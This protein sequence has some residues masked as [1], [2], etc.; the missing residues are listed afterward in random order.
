[1]SLLDLFRVRNRIVH[2]LPAE[3]YVFLHLLDQDANGRQISG[4]VEIAEGSLSN[5]LAT[6]AY[7]LDLEANCLADVD[8]KELTINTYLTPIVE[9]D[10]DFR[11]RILQMASRKEPSFDGFTTASL[12]GGDVWKHRDTTYCGSWLI[13]L[14]CHDPELLN[15]SADV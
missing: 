9:H 15:S 10:S 7:T 11:E 3:T 5:Q 1:M 14:N 2:E 8:I 4:T 6:L 13:E 12:F